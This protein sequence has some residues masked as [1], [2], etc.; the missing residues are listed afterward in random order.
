MN[1]GLFIKKYPEKYLARLFSRIFWPPPSV[2]VLVHGEN[3]DILV[4]N[5]D[6]EYRLP[7]GL[8]DSGE[9]PREAAKREVLEE[10]G[11]EIDLHNI[12]DVR[13]HDKGG[14]TI[15]FEADVKEGE[16]SGSWEGQP[17]FVPKEEVREKV[18]A[19]HHSHI[20]EYLF[21]ED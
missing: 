7:G 5:L 15:F 14:F 18:W 10:T 1:L 20:H 9:D 2:T 17:E 13:T 4:L 3:E 6:G 11:F 21:P 19:L 12:L 16:K 8:I